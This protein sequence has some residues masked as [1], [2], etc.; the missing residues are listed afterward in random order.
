M[1]VFALPSDSKFSRPQSYSEME[2]FGLRSFYGKTNAKTPSSSETIENT[3]KSA[4]VDIS[5]DNELNLSRI[6]VPEND[7]LIDDLVNKNPNLSELIDLD[8]FNMS[9]ISANDLKGNLKSDKGI[10]AKGQM[11]KK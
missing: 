4:I 5:V 2:F 10:I 7:S 3:E 11:V 8:V 6:S 1:W 9:I